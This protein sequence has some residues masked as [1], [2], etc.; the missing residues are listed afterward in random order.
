MRPFCLRLLLICA[1]LSSCS[2]K[3]EVKEEVAVLV[4]TYIVD[5]KNIP[6]TFEFVGICESSHLVEIRSRVQGYIKEVAYKEGRLIKEGQLLFKIDDREF[7]AKL[8]ETKAILEKEKAILWSAE[9]A[10]ERYKPL[11][12]QKAASRR[13]WEDATAQLLAQQAVVEFNQARVQEAELSLSYTEILSPISGYTTDARFQEGTLITPGANDLLTTVTVLDPIWV[14]ANIADSYFLET[15]QDIAEGKLKVPKDYG[16][17]VT[18]TLSDGTEYSY[19]GKVNFLSPLLNPDTGTL[20][21]R[22]IFPNPQGLL[23]PGQF[24]RAHAKGAERVDAV[25]VPQTSVLQG[26]QGSFV[27]VV[28]GDKV[29]KREVVPGEWYGDY[30]I[31]KSGLQKGDEVIREGV[32]KVKEGT[33]VKVLNRPKKR[34]ARNG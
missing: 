12:E 6:I 17:D 8:A 13:D 19:D 2:K 24:V 25:I 16:Y 26:D 27:Y 28:V 23:K 3:N 4:T 10:V 32:N 1:L 9:K 31:I 14:V 7:Q 34:T 21:A 22:A 30:W 29:T 18:L 11:Y 33:L 15:R 20:S 5:P